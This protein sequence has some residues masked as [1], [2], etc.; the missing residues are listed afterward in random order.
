ML[1]FLATLPGLLISYAIFK[2]DKYER[3]PFMPLLICYVLGALAT[4]PA[5]GFEK[6]VFGMIDLH[7]KDFGSVFLLSFGV[8]ALIEE[9]LKFAVLYLYVL[10]G[11]FF[12]EPIDG[13]VYAVLIAMG[14]ATMENITYAERFGAQTVILRSFTAVP[15]H[16]V[17]AIVQGYFAGLVRLNAT[18]KH[19]L[20]K[21]GLLISIGMHGLYDF[22]IFQNWS[23]WLFVLATVSLYMCLFYSSR[24]IKAHLDN[25][26]FR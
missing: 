7:Q 12:N 11:K 10:R 3:E 16:F 14:F 17:F 24:L 15:A 9:L 26:P 2:V 6:W 5:V 18:Q 25:S 8:V 1:L 4:I 22:L 23:D 21:R 13:I 20:L 19:A